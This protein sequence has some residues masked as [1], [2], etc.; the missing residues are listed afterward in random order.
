MLA[1]SSFDR[2]LPQANQKLQALKFQ[3]VKQYI[4]T[5]VLTLTLFMND[6]PWL[7]PVC[8]PGRTQ[9]WQAVVCWQSCSEVGMHHLGLLVV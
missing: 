9:R 4:F 2:I 3:P 5:Q 7:Y 8:G 6:S 1:P